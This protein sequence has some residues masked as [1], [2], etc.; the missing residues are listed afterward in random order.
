MAFIAPLPAFGLI[1]VEG[2]DAQTF[3]HGQLTN[4]LLHLAPNGAQWTGYCTA[5]G[6]MLAGFL[7]WRDGPEAFYLATDRTILPALVKRLTMYVLRAKVKL[8]DASTQFMAF[9][10]Q[11]HAE[12]AALT[13][14]NED[15]VWRVAL[16]SLE[17]AARRLDWVPTKDSE[18]YA[19]TTGMP[20]ATAEIWMRSMVHAGEAWITQ[21]TQ[22]Q[23]V[24]Q[25]V[26]FDAVGGIS[27]KKGCYPG[28]EIVARAHYRGAVK[29]RMYR[30][31]VAAPAQAGDILFADDLNGQESGLVALAAPGAAGGCDILAVLQMQSHDNSTIHLGSPDGPVLAFAPLPYS[32]PEP[33]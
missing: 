13:A 10:V 9:G 18:T 8:E 12:Q 19:A 17:G 24:P 7:A 11:G 22:E 6:R 27:F 32:L 30:A 3:L 31:T 4:D 26:N 20:R 14:K 33:L 1:R 5:K 2:P 16:P 28:Q 23:F 25:M 15:G 29:R 21:A